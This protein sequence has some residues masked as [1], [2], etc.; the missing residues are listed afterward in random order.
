MVMDNVKSECRE[1]NG[2][3]KKD[4]ETK[5][6]EE[7]KRERAS[8]YLHK[9]HDRDGREREQQKRGRKGEDIIVKKQ[10]PDQ[11]DEAPSQPNLPKVLQSV[12]TLLTS[13]RHN[14]CASDLRK[15]VPSLWASCA[16]RIRTRLQRIYCSGNKRKVDAIVTSPGCSWS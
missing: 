9:Q 13:M 16:A 8:Y 7:T 2:N 5:R 11:R 6:E 3:W 12:L 4:V 1:W 14:F 10:L 15:G